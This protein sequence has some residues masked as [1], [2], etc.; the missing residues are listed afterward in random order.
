MQ[1]P[2]VWMGGP[3]QD[4]MVEEMVGTD[5]HQEEE[6]VMGQE[7]EEEQPVRIIYLVDKAAKA[8]KAKTQLVNQEPFLTSTRL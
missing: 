7:V 4:L 2:E 8:A 3:A 1:Q 5:M 6:D